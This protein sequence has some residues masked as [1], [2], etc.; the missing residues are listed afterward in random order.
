MFY[1]LFSGI[2]RLLFRIK[3]VNPQNEPPEG[4][5]VVCANHISAS[6]PVVVCYAFKHHQIRYMAKKELFKIPILSSLLR[7]LGAFPIDRGGS[8]VGAIKLAVKQVA[9]GKCVG[10]FPQGHR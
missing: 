7:S 2:I 9:E 3:V 10:V 5:F 8:D 1:F 6:D 4:G